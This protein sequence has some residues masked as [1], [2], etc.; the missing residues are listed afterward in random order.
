MYSIK[1]QYI[2]YPST[3]DELRAV[4]ERYETAHL[5]G[6]AGSIDVVHL[7]WGN[8]P[9]GDINQCKGKEGYPT[10]AFEVISGFDREILGV[11]SVQFGTRNDQHIVKIDENVDRIKN[12][13]YKLVEW[14]HYDEYGKKHTSVG[15]YFV[16][17]GGF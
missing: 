5:P 6:C 15:V 14:E 7:K 4:M 2:K 13:W 17:D 12:E 8:C 3:Y 16:C 10:V 9:A 1:E 11:S